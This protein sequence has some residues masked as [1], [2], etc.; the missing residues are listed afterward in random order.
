MSSEDSSDTL[1]VLE[2]K[3]V[4]IPT[5][6]KNKLSSLGYVGIRVLAKIDESTM[7][8]IEEFVGKVLGSDE[9]TKNMSLTERQE[10][11]GK[12]FTSNPKS[13]MLLPVVSL[14]D[15]RILYGRTLLQYKVKTTLETDI[16]RRTLLQ[17]VASPNAH[18]SAAAI[19]ATSMSHTTLPT[20]I[21]TLP[22]PT[23]VTRGL[24]VRVLRRRTTGG[25]PNWGCSFPGISASAFVSCASGVGDVDSSLLPL[26][27]AAGT[28]KRMNHLLRQ[29]TLPL[30][31]LIR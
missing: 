4:V 22:E 30:A 26:S 23:N 9:M 20:N 19:T 21:T 8:E 12:T 28:I 3:H 13:F 18:H 25:G 6:I 11:F 24:R 31:N 5:H 17:R 10:Q 16:K 15:L 7:K 2:E 14:K 27:V 29:S 1:K